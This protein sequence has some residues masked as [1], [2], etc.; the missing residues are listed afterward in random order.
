MKRFSALLPAAGPLIAILFALVVFSDR[1]AQKARAQGTQQAAD[2]D[3]DEDEVRPCPERP[4]LKVEYLLPSEAGKISHIAEA[5][6]EGDRRLI[7]IDQQRWDPLPEA[8][9][10]FIYNHELGHHLIGHAKELATAGGI[11][12]PHTRREYEEQADCYAAHTFAARGMPA[13]IKEVEA[14][15][16]TLPASEHWRKANLR[17]CYDNTSYKPQG[18]AD[19]N[20]HSYLIYD[21]SL[22]LF[23]RCGDPAVLNYTVVY[24]NGGRVPLQCEVTIASGH[25]PRTAPR[26]DMSVWQPFET[27]T[28]KFILEPNGRHAVRGYLVWF[29]LKETMPHIRIPRPE[30]ETEYVRCTFAPGAVPPPKPTTLDFKAALPKLIEAS[31]G[32]FA[33]LLGPLTAEDRQYKALLALPEAEECTVRIRSGA[34]P[35]YHCWLKRTNDRQAVDR[36][37][38]EIVA[39]IRAWLPESWEAEEGIDRD[40]EKRFTAGWK[41]DERGRGPNINIH[42]TIWDDDGPTKRGKYQLSVMFNGH[43][44]GDLKPGSRR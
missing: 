1:V 8:V 25:R 10:D 34:E 18:P 17:K 21:K 44:G 3:G 9:K 6:L 23:A 33:S 36:Q 37:Y 31:G 30:E 12:N 22:P 43:W 11:L 29:R 4:P 35:E 32:G 15:I 16:D 39:K 28:D 13:Q 19:P 41:D 40:K 24:R 38:G 20:A 27:Q 5:R 42:L 26:N 2:A 7:Y 14:F